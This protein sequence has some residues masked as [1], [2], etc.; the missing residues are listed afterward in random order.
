M[1]ITREIWAQDIAGNLFAD[2]SFIM[3]SIS[4]DVFVDENGTVHLPQA[5]AKPNVE[6]NRSSLPATVT[7]RTDVIVSYDLDEYTSDPTLIKDIDAME[8]SYDKRVSVTMEHSDTLQEKIALWMAYHWG[9]D[10]ITQMVR[11]TGANRAAFVT[12]ATGT[13]KKITYADFLSAKRILDAQNIPIKGRVCVLPAEMYNDLFELD[14]VINLQKQGTPTLP[15][16]VVANILG[17]DIM[18]RSELVSYTNASTPVKRLPGAADLTS[19]NAA[20]LFYHENFVRRAKGAVKIFANED[21]APY[22]GSIF[23]ALAKAGG[24][25]RYTNG[26]GVV[27]LVEAAGV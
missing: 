10:D 21:Q 4:D 18:M 1:A 27:A 7:E 15:S 12:G 20:A 26:R 14:E 25:K 16:G 22:Y 6:R 17:F 13:R 5:G 24:R 19:A 23:S 9:A 2:D 11:T 3:R 8:V